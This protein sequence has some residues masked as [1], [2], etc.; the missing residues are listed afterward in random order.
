MPNAKAFITTQS[1]NKKLIKYEIFDAVIAGIKKVFLQTSGYNL[2]MDKILILKMKNKATE[3]EEKMK[4][5]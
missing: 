3:L 1:T 4:Y 5:T 2:K